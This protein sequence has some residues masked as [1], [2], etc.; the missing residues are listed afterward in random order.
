MLVTGG[1]G[2]IGSHLVDRLLDLGQSVTVYDNFSTGQ[3][4]FLERAD[5]L[6]MYATL[7]DAPGMMN[8]RL[9]SLLAVTPEQIQEATEA[10]LVPENRV[11]LSYVP[12][13]AR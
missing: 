8:D 1:A 2:F 9:P 11:V 13:E 4:D 5:H 7:F 10:I 12:E 6:S 3:T